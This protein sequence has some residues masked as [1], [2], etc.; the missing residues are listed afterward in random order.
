MAKYNEIEIS[1]LTPTGSNTSVTFTPEVIREAIID[2]LRD[3]EFI[4]DDDDAD[5]YIHFGPRDDRYV[6]SLLEACK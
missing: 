2:H 5:V 3:L 4:D 1:S 6:V